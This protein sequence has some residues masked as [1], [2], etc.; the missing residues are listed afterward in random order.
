MLMRS[1]LVVLF[2]AMVIAVPAAAQEADT[3]PPVEVSHLT[4]PLH[5]LLCNGNAR[6]VASVGP[7]GIL[8]VDSGFGA[9]AEAL[10]EALD[11]FES[12][13]VRIIINTHG[14][15]DHVGGNAVVGEDA[16]I[17]AHPAVRRLM[18]TY[19]AL[20]A[21]STAGMPQVSVG[22]GTTVF[23][24]G[25]VIKVLP[26]PGGHTAGDMVV[27]FTKTGVACLGDV[28]LSGT[29]P[30]AD[31]AR[32]GDAK[33]L[34][35]VLRGLKTT[36]PADTVLVPAHGEVLS[37]N[38]LQTYIDMVEDT[39]AA[40]ADEVSAGR[41]LETILERRPLA[42]WNEW[43]RP[44]RRLGLD[45]WTREIYASLTGG[46]TTS[47]CRPM[48]EALVKDDVEAAVA[49]YRD[50]KVEQPE[51]WSF[52]EN[53]LNMLGYQ[54]L[55]RGMTED[56]IVIFKLNVEAFP[57]GFNTYD[58]LA[59]GYMTAGQKEPAVTNYQ[60]SL[61]LNPDNTNATDMLTRLQGE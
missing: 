36:L 4:G 6:A 47:I 10:Q 7:D 43:A 15:A 38:G 18:G 29:F 46:A 27:H 11:G 53:E 5:L 54:L 26:V 51:T 19:F 55:Q 61:E 22:S 28:V 44:D 60:R 8:L 30:N 9:T 23:F 12:G 50:L 32:G 57:E 58:S 42:P 1:C 35:K 13:P 2:L 17:L 14:D 21:V 16:V 52:A 48:T 37:M 20:P 56:A 40:V 3:P 41:D 34:A 49:V 39:T 25:D 24:N 45:D 31:P 59:E 33:R